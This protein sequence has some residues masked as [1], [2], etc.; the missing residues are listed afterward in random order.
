MK[1]SLTFVKTLYAVF[2]TGSVF[3]GNRILSQSWVLGKLGEEHV[4]DPHRGGCEQLSQG[5]LEQ[6]QR[7]PQ[8]LM[9]HPGP[10]G[11]APSLCRIGSTSRASILHLFSP[12][13]EEGP[14]QGPGSCTISSASPRHPELP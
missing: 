11:G 8:S 14:G 13:P 10:G 3:C 12:S 6:K 1:D 2:C 9:S 5:L 4:R 7:L